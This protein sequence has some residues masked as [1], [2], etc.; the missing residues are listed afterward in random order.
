MA[1]AAGSSEETIA[2]NIMP[3]LDVFS[4]LIIFLLMNFSTDPSKYE[5]VKGIEIPKSATLLSLDEVPIITVT[6]EELRFNGVNIASINL[7]SPL[8]DFDIKDKKGG[9][10]AI[11]AL[12]QEL[13]KMNE[14]NKKRKRLT[15]SNTDPDAPPDALTLEMDKSHNFV[16][17]RRIMKSA[18]QAEF[19]SFK[20][21]VNKKS[22]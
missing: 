21:M 2:I 6:K 13:E 19:I 11:Y 1:Q 12:F 22:K 5:P 17:L 14:A 9:Q 7:D 16:I 3:L 10:G 18:Q 8:K 15:G 20:L 4:I